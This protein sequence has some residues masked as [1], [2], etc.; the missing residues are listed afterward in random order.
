MPET[1]SAR[2]LSNCKQR[3]D[4]STYTLDRWLAG[5][6]I[7]SFVNRPSVWCTDGTLDRQAQSYNF[8]DFFRRS[9]A[10]LGD[11]PSSRGRFEDFPRT[12][13]AGSAT[14]ASAS[15]VFLRRNGVAFG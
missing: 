12:S 1:Y 13:G 7:A 6:L 8:E 14:L 5:Y 11:A 9:G 10:G 3:A 15:D 4:I 2:R